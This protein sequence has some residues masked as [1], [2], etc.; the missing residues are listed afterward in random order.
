MKQITVNEISDNWNETFLRQYDFGFCPLSLWLTKSNSTVQNKELDT[1]FG[2]RKKYQRVERWWTESDM[3]QKMLNYQIKDIGLSDIKTLSQNVG[4]FIS[5]LPEFLLVRLL[6]LFSELIL[7]HEQKFDFARE[8]LQP[9]VIGFVDKC[10]ELFLTELEAQGKLPSFV[11]SLEVVHKSLTS[12][13]WNWENMMK[14]NKD[15]SSQNN[16][17]VCAVVSVA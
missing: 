17:P 1:I 16:S 13:T 12:T 11:H 2:E 5:R 14:N 3:E 7:K 4:V 9:K 10:N 8:F 6:A 15:H